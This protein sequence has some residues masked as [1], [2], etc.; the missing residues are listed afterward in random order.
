MNPT[1]I[2]LCGLLCLTVVAFGLRP[3][4]LYATRVHIVSPFFCPGLEH[5]TAITPAWQ[6]SYRSAS[7]WWGLW[8]WEKS[9]WAE[10]G[11]L[12]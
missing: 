3:P 7:T 6:S 10:V 11:R 8:H 9:F 4:P 1:F 2:M 12:S 5:A